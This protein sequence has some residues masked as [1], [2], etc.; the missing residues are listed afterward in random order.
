MKTPK[1][2]SATLIASVIFCGLASFRPIPKGAKAVKPFNQKKY[3]GT[4][5]EIARLDYKWERNLNNVTATYSLREDGKIKVDNRG[6]NYK[7]NKWEESVGKAKPA[8]DPTEGRL[9]VSFFGP[10]YSEYNVI[11]LDQDYKYALVAGSNTK[12]LWILSREKTIPEKVKLEY[13]EKAKS[14]GYKIEDLVWVEHG[15]NPVGF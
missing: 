14:L 4:W 10:F 15:K 8:S 11:A 3:L 7:K 12:Y 5:Y 2:I 1:F 9:K 6:Y 13:L